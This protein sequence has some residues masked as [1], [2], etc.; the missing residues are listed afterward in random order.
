MRK[1]AFCKCKIKGAD[2]LRCNRAADQCLCFRYVYSTSKIQNFKPL[3]IFC[4]CTARFVS[5][6]K[7][8]FLVMWL[9]YDV[10]IIHGDNETAA[11]VVSS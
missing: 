5:N 8:G 6:L 3:A 10:S 9:N 1:P 11:I 2:L 4:G 7:I